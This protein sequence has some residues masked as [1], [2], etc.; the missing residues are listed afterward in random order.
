MN[1]MRSSVLGLMLAV[2]LT[3]S[4]FASYTITP[5]SGSTAGGTQVTI[6]GGEFGLWPYG[7][8]FGGAEVPATRVDEHTLVATTPAHVP[9]PVSIT[10]FEY[11]LGLP[12]DL[13]FSFYEARPAPFYERILLPIFTPP[14]KGA[15]GSEFHTDLRVSLKEPVT[16]RIHGLL[17]A[18]AF[19]PC[20]PMH[21][22]A[23]PYTLT[24]AAPDIEPA[25]LERSGAPGR[26]IYVP[27]TEA[28]H[29]AMNLRAYDVTRSHENF[30]T[31]MP[32][33]RARDFAESYS[34]IK[35]LGVPRDPRFRN[36]L[37]IYG[38]GATVISMR[39][40]A[41][42]QV[43]QR[44]LELGDAPD[45]FTPAYAQ[46]GDLPAGTGTMNITLQVPI[47]PILPPASEAI[48]AFVTVTNNET[49]L[50]STITPR[51]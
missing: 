50:I 35:L 27:V 33:V 29:I 13:T 40:E 34:A 28:Q 23:E 17:P 19:P 10:I 42:G 24:P 49:Q 22:D 9:G 11:D 36:T 18:C 7:I 43:T 30:G 15:F 5:S 46:I 51:P 8:I 3:S 26:F 4:L 48:W 41:D 38:T 39:I 37:R 16:A 2:S 44:D 32:I 6:K 12:T 45:P 47:P 25:A 14:V 31:E 21:A 20:A 1:D